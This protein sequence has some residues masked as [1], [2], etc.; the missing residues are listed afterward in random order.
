VIALAAGAL[1]IGTRVHRVAIIL[2]AGAVGYI[3]LR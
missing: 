1:I 2:A 3:W